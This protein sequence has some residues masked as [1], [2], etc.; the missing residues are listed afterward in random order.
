[1]KMM[2]NT[3]F[4]VVL[5]LGSTSIWSQ[6][7]PE[8][9]FINSK[10]PDFRAMDQEGNEIRLK[11]VLK[12]GPVVLV[13]YR[14]YWCP[15]C[16]KYLM[17][18]QDSLSLIRDK[19]A[20]VIAISPQLTEGTQKTKEKINPA[21]L[22]VSDEGGKIMKSYGVAF[23]VDEKTLGRYR[24]A[25][26][27]L[28]TINGQSSASLPIPAIYIINKEGTILYRFFDSDYKKRASIREILSNL[29]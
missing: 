2:R 9:L 21:Y 13:F 1:M 25:D 6:N 11:D 4:L 16:N 7:K 5:I 26:I 12:Q 8:G 20:Q 24:N 17:R 18:L 29:D 14:G 3:F 10:A 22:L 28:V 27:D 23:A 15:Y 19:G